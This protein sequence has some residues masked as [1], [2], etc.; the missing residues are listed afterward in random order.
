MQ[1][2]NGVSLADQ[3][4]SSPDIYGLSVFSN[5]QSIFQDLAFSS[6]VQSLQ[7]KNQ[8]QKVT[9]NSIQ[10]FQLAGTE[11]DWATSHIPPGVS[12]ILCST[13]YIQTLPKNI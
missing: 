6:S 1:D 13:F 2:G 4:S 11:G 9:E 7:T 5:H 12:S 3:V 8:V 10:K